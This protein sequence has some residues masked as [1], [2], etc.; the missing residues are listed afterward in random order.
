MTTSLALTL[1]L[2]LFSRV[3]LFLTPWSI[4]YWL[5]LSMGFSRQE[6]WSGLPFPSPRD[7]L[8]P[9]MDPHILHW[10]ADSLS[11]SYLGSPILNSQVLINS[12]KKIVVAQSLSHVW[13][14][15]PMECNTPSFPVLHCLPDFAQTHVHW[16]SDAIQPS[17]PLFPLLNLSQYQGLF[18][19]VSSLHQVE[20]Y[21]SFSFSVSPSSEN[22]GL[23]SFGI[24]WFDLLAVQRTLKS[25]LQYHSLKASILW[26]SAFFMIQ[27]SHTYM[28]TKKTH[29]LDYTYLCHQSNVST[30]QYAV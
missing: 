29:S 20:K 30:F 28:T 5:P 18:Q 8:D 25:L 3:Q 1:F 26:C 27:F 11:L 2:L 21:W 13:F 14:C 15:N 7:L 24:D 12:F 6:Y 9:R 10:Q 19:W 22:S 16:V 23:I 17:H 4:A